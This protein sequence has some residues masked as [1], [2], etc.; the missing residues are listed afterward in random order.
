ME[1]AGRERKSIL[2][3][4]SDE[5]LYA[6][7]S[8]SNFSVSL[9]TDDRLANTSMISLLR[10]SF[11]NVF[12]N[13][14]T[15][16]DDIF[17]IFDN[18][19][20]ANISVTINQGFYSVND[21]IDAIEFGGPGGLLSIP[22][23]GIQGLIT[24]GDFTIDSTQPD[25]KLVFASTTTNIALLNAASGSTMSPTLGIILDSVG[26]AASQTGDYIPN[27]NGLDEVWLRS[28]ELTRP[29]G[30][31]LILGN[32][33]L[34]DVICPIGISVP[35]LGVQNYEPPDED[36]FRVSYPRLASIKTPD[37]YLTDR[38]NNILDLQGTTLTAVFKVDSF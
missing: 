24:G 38:N 17:T 35:F 34:S 30:S 11:S 28:R 20:A 8:N 12:Y 6:T 16:I 18:T 29:A 27:L 14:R 1:V 13:I 33:T 15:N 5:K 26:V 37:L 32:N 31:N 21:L 25:S 3:I 10:C 23:G 7:Q 9:S 4:S 19:A 36:Y 22:N 2:R